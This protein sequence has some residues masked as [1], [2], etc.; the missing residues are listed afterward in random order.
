MKKN[1]G[2]NSSYDSSVFDFS[3]LNHW[4]LVMNN[5]EAIQSMFYLSAHI[6]SCWRLLDCLWLVSEDKNQTRTERQHVFVFSFCL[7]KINRTTVTEE[8]LHRFLISLSRFIMLRKVKS[9]MLTI[10]FSR[11]VATPTQIHLQSIQRTLKYLWAAFPEGSTLK[12][13]CDR[14]TNARF[15]YSR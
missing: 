12:L 7:S 10:Y 15:A 2:K 3:R 9:L 5:A 4:V 8:I 11:C 1:E 13:P 6:T 14:R